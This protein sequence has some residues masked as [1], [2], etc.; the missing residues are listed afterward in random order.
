MTA[1][2]LRSTAC[3]R[4]RLYA[5]DLPNLSALPL[6][7]LR[8]LVVEDESL[9]AIDV[10]QRCRDSGASGV[11]IVSTPARLDGDVEFFDAAIVE[12]VLR[13]ASTAGFARSLMRRGIPF[14]FGTAH[15][16]HQQLFREFPGV[17]VVSKPYGGADLVVTLARAVRFSKLAR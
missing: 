1:K 8:V 2:P 14:V 16:D 4:E 5:R 10:E 6:E 13:G 3:V 9:I 7:G 12:V 11:T 15:A 17:A